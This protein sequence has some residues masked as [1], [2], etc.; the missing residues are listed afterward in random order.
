MRHVTQGGKTLLEPE[1]RTHSS[2]RFHDGTPVCA[3]GS[4]NMTTEILLGRSQPSR[5][6]VD[7]FASMVC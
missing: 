2:V 5:N 7:Q 6:A 1:A 4:D 3:L